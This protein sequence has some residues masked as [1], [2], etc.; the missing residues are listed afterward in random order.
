MTLVMELSRTSRSGP[1]WFTLSS[2]WSVFYF[3]RHFS[4]RPSL[5][6]VQSYYGARFYGALVAA[7]LGLELLRLMSEQVLS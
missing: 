5:R 4:C 3:W 2:I 7:S 1:V 6:I